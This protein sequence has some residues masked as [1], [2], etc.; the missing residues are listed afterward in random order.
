VLDEISFDTGA[1]T[2]S[3][4]QYCTDEVAYLYCAKV[5]TLSDTASTLNP[6]MERL[7]IQGV[8]GH[9]AIDRAHALVNRVNVGGSNTPSQLQA[10]GATQIQ[11]YR[12][13]LNRLAGTR[14]SQSYPE[15]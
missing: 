6:I 14:Q 11:L 5:H 12:A 9:A 3:V 8:A 13:G 15:G 10:W 7:L 1:D 4:T 2:V